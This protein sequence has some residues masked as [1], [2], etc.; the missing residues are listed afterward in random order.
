[1]QYRNLANGRRTLLDARGRLHN[2]LLRK[3]LIAERRW[4]RPKLIWDWWPTVL[5]T[6]LIVLICLKAIMAA[7]LVWDSMAYH[8][9]FSALRVGLMKHWQFQ[10][11]SPEKDAVAGYYLGFPI[12]ADLLRGW[13]W[14]FSGRAEAVNL[15][16][17]ISILGLVG[18]LKWAFRL[19]G[20]WVVIGV[21]AIPAVQTAAAGNYVD[22]PANC[23]FTIFLFSLCD[24]WS[25]PERFRRPAPWVVMFLAAFA[26]ANIKLQMSVYVC[27][28]LPFVAP[29]VWRL[30]REQHAG[31]KTVAGTAFAGLV[32]SL[33]IAVN[34][35]KNLIRYHNPL[36]PIDI[37]FAGVHLA[38]PVTHDAWL[39]P[40]GAYANLAQPFTWLLSVLEYRA[41]DG[42]DVPYS[43]G[44]GNVPIT[45]PASSMGGFFSALVIVSI[46][47]LVLC[48]SKRH[49]RLSVSVIIVLIG[50]SIV[51]SVFPDSQ[52]LR[53]EIFWMMFLVVGSLLLLR[54]PSLYPHLQSY[55]IMLFASLVF[56]TSVTGGIYFTPI[57]NPMQEYVDRSGAERLLEAVV[58]PGDVI[59]LPQGPGSWDSRFTI[60]FAPIFHK[61]LAAERPYAVREGYCD[62]YQTI[63]GWR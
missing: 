1:M 4:L 22:V 14:K 38:G 16:G 50:S 19:E 3:A 28:T 9:P 27:L 13:M 61:K 36:Y 57:W 42:R 53:Y 41:L 26:A 52:N 2:S 10:R 45:S 25:N 62:G 44:M 12:L 40:N 49:D 56:V 60:M 37:E 63:S 34:L 30:L 59:C 29:Q 39:L 20:A 24:L 15:L 17:I 5:A 31:W 46:C 35:L 55:K 43:N 23:A 18:Y 21:L 7:D 51:L 47:F 33:L 11:P 54:S 48:V 32:A 58:E 8:M 6:V